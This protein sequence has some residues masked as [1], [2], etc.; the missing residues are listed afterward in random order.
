MKIP[1]SIS[2]Q[3]LLV[4]SAFGLCLLLP[5]AP[6][7]ASTGY[8]F[9]PP[10]FGSLTAP[11]GAAIDQATDNLFVVD[12]GGVEA[13]E[14]YG[15]TGGAPS[16]GGPAQLTGA[17]TPGGEFR[18]QGEPAAVAIDNSGGVSNGDVYVTDVLDGVVDKFRLNATHEYE[19]ITQ[20]TGFSEPLGVTVDGSG[21]VYVADYGHDVVHEFDA[22][23]NEINQ[24]TTPRVT[25]PQGV[26]VDGSGDLYIQDY[27]SQNLVELE[28]NP[29][30]EVLSEV[31]IAA[32]GVTAVAADRSTNHVFVDFGSEIDEYDSAGNVITDLGSGTL[33]A[34]RGLAIDEASG[35]VYADDA[36]NGVVDTFT[37]LTFPDAF[38]KPA[39][40]VDPSSATLNG[41]IRPDGI[42]ASSLQFEYGLSSSYEN[43][44]AAS[45][46]EV[47]GNTAEASVT[48]DLTALE[49]NRTYHYRFVASSVSGAS[50]GE[51]ETFVTAV[52]PSVEGVAPTATD[53]T[54]RGALLSG[55][56]DAE[57]A[58]TS[59][60][61]EYG[62]SAGYGHS[63]LPASAGAALGDVA[64]PSQMLSELQPATTY[65]YRLVASNAA[66][67]TVGADQAF[68]TAAATPPAASSGAPTA[69]T[70]STAT[71]AGSVNPAGLPT[72]YEFD[73][74]TDT[75]YGTQTFGS[76]SAG[77]T[78]ETV[79]LALTDLAPGTTY[80]Y[81]LIASNEDGT[82][83]GSDQSF[84]TPGLSTFLTLPTAPALVA[85]PVFEP[86]R[87]TTKP[88]KPKPHAKKPAKKKRAKQRAKK[89]S[90]KQQARQ[91]AKKRSKQPRAKQRE[92]NK[93][94]R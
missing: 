36:E 33:G 1:L 31:E 70:Q 47:P 30:G 79:T 34:S 9:L 20:L 69:V 14:I 52:K 46:T 45:M 11:T 8:G 83:Y 32:A 66:G 75:N 40:N 72:S 56:I 90:K 19:Y 84:T 22:A 57:N 74:G 12:G 91:R 80:H 78:T 62:P 82:A 89:Q 42:A 15:S 51:D 85:T 65:H 6:A 60:T 23:G 25:R 55:T 26:A 71:I 64:V 61:F 59:Y 41:T 67:T 3:R 93:V 76:V 28:R 58:P 86:I 16:G 24:F 81:R 13:V 35:D 44:I 63:T 2:A 50:V 10:A 88:K 18:I 68:T 21:N 43:T 17:S 38:T 73:L 53:I 29:A 37:L 48:A 54:R 27:A 92:K 77:S 7:L 5:S 4:L 87:V 49:P 94:K 39:T